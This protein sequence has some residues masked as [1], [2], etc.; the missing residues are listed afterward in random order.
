MEEKEYRCKY[1]DVKVSKYVTIC[2][3]CSKKLKLVKQL[4]KIGEA[5][6]EGTKPKPDLVEVVRCK[7]CA[8]CGTDIS[9]YC[10]KYMIWVDEDG[11]CSYGQRSDTK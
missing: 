5:I 4:I 1:C 2:S 3:E 9:Y 6:K 11:Y 10:R 7:N 8:F